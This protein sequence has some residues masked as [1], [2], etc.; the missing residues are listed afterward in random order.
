MFPRLVSSRL[1]CP[2]ACAALVWLAACAPSCVADERPTELVFPAPEINPTAVVWRTADPPA[3]PRAGDVWVCSPDG[4]A[5]VYVPSGEF[6]MGSPPGEGDE[7]EH[8]QRSVHL[9]GFWMDKAEVT[10][11][12]YARF[13]TATGHPA[14]SFFYQHWNHSRYTHPHQPVVGVSW[15]DAAAYAEW[16]GKRLPTESEWEK[17]ARGPDGRRYPWGSEWD[18]QTTRRCNFSDCNDPVARSSSTIDDGYGY[19]APVGSY[20]RGA[21]PYGCLDMAG[22]VWEWCAD[23]YDAAYYTYGETYNPKGPPTG[24]YR[25]VRGGCWLYDAPY[26]RGAARD[27]AY[28]S[29]RDFNYGGFRCVKSER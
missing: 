12:E 2:A 6:R 5:M 20:P 22:N 14:P 8:P 18:I 11:A 23:W 24:I 28:P 29:C 9:N 13:L 17:A 3:H 4:E 19:P 1:L 7:D 21:S 15:D 16:A 10:N 26:L 27:S 25:V